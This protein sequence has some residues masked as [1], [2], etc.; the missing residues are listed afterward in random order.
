MRAL[1]WSMVAVL[2]LGGVA[3]ADAK[4]VAPDKDKDNVDIS[5]YRSELVVLSDDDGNFYVA[6]PRELG[7]DGGPVFVGDGKTFYAQRLVGSGMDGSKGTWSYALWAPRVAGWDD[8]QLWLRDDKKF[9][10]SCGREKD[11]ELRRVSAKETTRILADAEFKPE[12]FQRKAHLLARDEDG[13]YYYV[14]I[15]VDP[16]VGKTKINERKFQ[17]GHRVFVGKKG[18]MKELPMTNVVA[19]SD[20]EIYQ[21]KRGE[22]RIVTSE[23]DQTATWVRG[24]KKTALKLLDVGANRYLVFRELG[25][26]SFLG[27]ACEEL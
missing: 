17:H 26:Y 12:L 19:D 13:T 24:R 14:D 15:D 18:A 23:S 4:P 27:T 21:T 25:I 9:F 11:T 10:L 8:A 20:G 16:R 6:R 3:V 7:R 2:G 1:A 22:L 5:S